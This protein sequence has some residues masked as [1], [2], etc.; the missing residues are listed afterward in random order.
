MHV[1]LGLL[2]TL[3]QALSFPLPASLVSSPNGD[4]IAYV[5]N[6][7]GVRSIWFAQAPQFQ[8]RMLWTSG[9]DDGQEITSLNISKDDKY[10]V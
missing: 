3:S 6:E 5:L 1:I 7:S 4:S 8:P 2:F 10:V 9:K